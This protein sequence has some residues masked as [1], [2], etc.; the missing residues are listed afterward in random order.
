M[1]GVV[2]AQ[3]SVKALTGEFR[4]SR[5]KTILDL[6]KSLV[7]SRSEAVKAPI[8]LITPDSGPYRIISQGAFPP[9]VLLQRGRRAS[10]VWSKEEIFQTFKLMHNGNPANHLY[11]GYFK[12]EGK[13]ENVW[14]RNSKSVTF[15]QKANEAIATICG[16]RIEGKEV[17]IGF[18]PFHTQ[19]KLSYWA[20]IDF[21]GKKGACPIQA[22]RAALASLNYT[23]RDYSD[24]YYVLETS[25]SG[26][27]HLYL[28]SGEMRHATEWTSILEDVVGKVASQLGKE[29]TAF[30]QKGIC[31]IFPAKGTHRRAC[32]NA[33]RAIGTFN[34]AQKTF[35]EI[36]CENLSSLLATLGPLTTT[37]EQEDRTKTKE[38]PFLVGHRGLVGGEWNEEGIRKL[39]ETFKFDL[40]QCE[41]RIGSRHKALMEL[42]GQTFSK[43]GREV[44]KGL[45]RYFFEKSGGTE[46]C[47]DLKAHNAEFDRC[48]K[49]MEE[50]LLQGLDEREQQV[51]EALP[52]QDLR[53]AFRI[54]R[55][56][57]LA[58]QMTRRFGALHFQVSVGSLALRL[59][60][61]SKHSGSR[62]RKLLIPT[63][64]EQVEPAV[65]GQHAALFRYVLRN[66]ATFVELARCPEGQAKISAPL[67]PPLRR[68]KAPAA[69]NNE[70]RM[71]PDEIVR[72]ADE[73]AR[74]KKAGA[75]DGLGK[76]EIR[77]IATT[78][79]LFGASY[80]EK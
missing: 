13:W 53:D 62:I 40:S 22:E 64:I 59:G 33:I 49:W 71:S 27:W 18:G 15:G 76:D 4:V 24:L 66:P 36:V 45:A 6:R 1:T 77:N 39:E 2:T 42:L 8:P 12:K 30:L 52:T 60:F 78:I 57:A 73:L 16:E 47:P 74:M 79:H 80:E 31:E 37:E 41:I 9:L 43:L 14:A 72:I 5:T 29:L 7:V 3:P 28:F 10:D 19:T 44:I 61:S 55:N 56:F 65:R 25:G 11:H 21:D 48:W 51:Y 17:M 75:L 38:E 70:T 26:G 23:F 50:D 20:A 34:G 32:G 63:V 67:K 46:E 58:A 68:E 54:V 69:S 35:S